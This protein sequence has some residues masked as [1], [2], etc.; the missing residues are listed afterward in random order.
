M[1][2]S[3]I[4]YNYHVMSSQ[5]SS[6]TNTDFVLQFKQP[7]IKLSTKS[8][9]VIKINSIEIPNSFDQIDGYSNT[10]RVTVT[11]ALLESKMGNIVFDKG[12]YSLSSL[13]IALKTLLIAFAQTAEVGYTA[14]TPVFTFS[15][16]DDT[17]LSSYTVNIGTFKLHFEDNR[18]LA[19][20]FGFESD[21]T[22]DSTIKKSN[23]YCITSPVSH[24]LLRASNLKQFQAVEFI[25]SNNNDYSDIIAK[26]VLLRGRNAWEYVTQQEPVYIMND[27]IDNINFYLTNNF[28]FNGIDLKGAIFSFSFTITEILEPELNLSSLKQNSR[29]VDY[30]KPAI[31]PVTAVSTQGPTIPPELQDF[32]PINGGQMAQLPDRQPIDKN[33]VL[34][35][36][37]TALTQT[38]IPQ[39]TNLDDNEFDDVKQVL[40]MKYEALKK[41]NEYKNRLK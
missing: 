22:I 24:L 6:G 29:V 25:V 26:L 12:T 16:N 37:T 40:K 30:K 23:F 39:D 27:S 9:F 10:L 17:G 31:Q 35:T 13:L 14:F 5:R 19:S 38:E 32:A 7:I 11:N 4:S 41:L 20:Q 1:A 15:K 36:S 3:L 21:F 34:G 28:N 2:Q 33:E 8:V 18:Q